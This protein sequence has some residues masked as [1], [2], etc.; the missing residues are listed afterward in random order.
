MPY[1]GV[2]SAITRQ[3]QLHDTPLPKLLFHASPGGLVT[4]KTLQWCRDNLENL[5]TIDIGAGIHFIQ[6]DNPHGIGSGLAAWYERLPE[7]T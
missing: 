6:E 5:E 7:A 4:K 2:A 3:P 1:S